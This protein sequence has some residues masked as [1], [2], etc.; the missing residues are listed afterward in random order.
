MGKLLP[1]LLAIAGLCA[2][3]GAGY[4]LKPE[5][6]EE[7]ASDAEVDMKGDPGREPD[8][9]ARES[10]GSYFEIANQFVVPV[11]KDERVDGMVILSI[12]L[13]ISSAQMDTARRLEPR[14]R[15]ALLRVLFDHAN[16][17]GFDGRFTETSRVRTLRDALVEAARGVAG[18]DVADVLILDLA[19]QDI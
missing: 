1:F 10:G 3:V 13:D 2:G 6:A 8:A 18:P 11:I 4:S 16:A 19:R 5:A 9:S 7:S 15:D 17:G 12:T 14:L